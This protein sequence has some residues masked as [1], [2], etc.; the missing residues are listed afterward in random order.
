MC[1]LLIFLFFLGFCWDFFDTFHHRS[2]LLFGSECKIAKKEKE[3]G[4]AKSLRFEQEKG[5]TDLQVG[6]KR[7]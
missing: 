6:H 3:K 4:F 7:R 1:P 5:S 2:S